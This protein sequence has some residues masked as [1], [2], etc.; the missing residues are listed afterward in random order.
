VPIKEAMQEAVRQAMTS[1]IDGNGDDDKGFFDKLSQVIRGSG[2]SLNV[3]VT[4]SNFDELLS[5][6]LYNSQ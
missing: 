4:N 6:L 3:N 5:V 1:S 2:E